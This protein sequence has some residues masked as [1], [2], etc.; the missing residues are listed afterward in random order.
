MNVV[1]RHTYEGKVVNTYTISSENELRD[2]RSLFKDL[3]NKHV[4][5]VIEVLEEEKKENELMVSLPLK[6]LLTSEEAIEYCCLNPYCVNEG[7]A[8]GTEHYEI[9]ISKAI[10]FG[11]LEDYMNNS[12]GDMV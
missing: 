1:H 12:M 6:V 5:M 3:E 8:D 7:L 11:F 9:P 2:I 4:R 10:Q